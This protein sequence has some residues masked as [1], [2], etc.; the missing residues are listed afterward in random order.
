MSDT[1]Y[2]PGVCNIGEAET[3]KRYKFGAIFFVVEVLFI[4]LVLWFNFGYWVL[5]LS[6][7]P[8]LLGFEGFYQGKFS[9]CA[10]FASRGMYDV[11]VDGDNRVNIIDEDSHK[12]DLK[13]A[14]R[15]HIYS[16]LTSVAITMIIYFIAKANII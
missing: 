8:L 14:R 10:S 15:I 12:K 11:S 9:F 1:D 5:I 4:S 6:F 3:N 13:K 16:V 7:I 2:E